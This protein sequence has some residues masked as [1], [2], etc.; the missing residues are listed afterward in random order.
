MLVQAIITAINHT[1]G[2]STTFGA[3]VV[4]VR[5]GDIIMHERKD[6][7]VTA[8]KQELKVHAGAPVMHIKMEYKEDPAC[9]FK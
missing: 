5:V 1:T 4:P 3:A 7:I 8:V 2:I 9:L 6:F